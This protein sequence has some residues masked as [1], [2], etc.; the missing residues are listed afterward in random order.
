MRRSE[1]HLDGT[2]GGDRHQIGTQATQP[3]GLTSEDGST[4]LATTNRLATSQRSPIFLGKLIQLSHHHNH[5]HKC[6]GRRQAV[7]GS[8]GGSEANSVT[9]SMAHQGEIRCRMILG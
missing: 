5:Y 1:P 7:V 2:Q 6:A 8:T 3:P 4:M 9:S